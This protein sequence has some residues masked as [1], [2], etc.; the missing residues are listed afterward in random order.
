MNT[1]LALIVIAVTA[2]L[3][4]DL[5]KVIV[6]DGLGHRPPPPSRFDDLEP[7]SPAWWTHVAH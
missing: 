2:A 4:W 5:V 6:G 7:G 1:F 3:I